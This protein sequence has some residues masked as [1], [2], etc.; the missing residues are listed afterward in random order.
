MLMITKLSIFFVAFVLT[1]CGAGTTKTGAKETFA[2][3]EPLPEGAVEMNV[4]NNRIYLSVTLNDTLPATMLLD[5]G[6]S[7]T[8]TVWRDF[9]T[10]H[11]IDFD[12][13]KV[14]NDDYNRRVTRS[15]TPLS[16]RLGSS[17]LD[18]KDVYVGDTFFTFTD[19]I[20]DGIFSPGFETER[21]IWE[22]NFEHNFVRVLEQ[23]RD[24]L[25]G[26]TLVFPAELSRRGGT[27]IVV[28]ISLSLADSSGN[29]RQL[30]K[31][32]VLDTG[33]PP[34]AAFFRERDPLGTG[35]TPSEV[36]V[37]DVVISD[38]RFGF[39]PE[40]TP[41]NWFAPDVAG[42]L[43]VGFLKHFNVF[44]DTGRGRVG[45]QNIKQHE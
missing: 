9:A 2:L 11:G 33:T 4:T 36:R 21:R 6:A 20:C 31:R 35:F 15:R 45:L 12:T 40:N 27:N 28:E 22:I 19:S 39:W 10:T 34:T 30:N 32:F 38:V 25:P 5:T 41:S 29:V 1:A 13:E 17:P 14:G 23:A 26:D 42:T 44:I 3:S 18:F 24:T 43:G 37:G 8:F 7:G 16:V